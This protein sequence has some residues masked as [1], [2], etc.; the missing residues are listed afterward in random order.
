[1]VAALIYIAT[2]T[3]EGFLSLKTFTDLCEFYFNKT[4]EENQITFDITRNV[5]LVVG[6][7]DFEGNTAEWPE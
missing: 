4:R 7:R 1:M 2:S 6:N 3:V 5:A